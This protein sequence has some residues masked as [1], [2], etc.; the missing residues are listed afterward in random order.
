VKD[1]DARYQSIKEVAIELKEL[2]REMEHGAI[3]A[4]VTTPKTVASEQPDV[5]STRSE[6][7]AITSKE[8]SLSTRAS[9]AEYV[10]TGIKQHKI[11]LVIALIVL[12]ASLTAF[13]LYLRG[14]SDQVAITSIAVMPFVNESGNADVE[15][16]SDGMTETLIGSLSSVPNLSVKPRATVFRYKGKETDARTIGRDL[17]VQAILNG[18]VAQRGDQIMLSLELIDAE[19][20]IVL[21]SQQYDRKQSSIVLLQTEIAKDVSTK[22]K[23]RLTGAAK[24][25]LRRQSPPIPKRIRLI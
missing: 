17:N 1:R 3:D 19:K 25:R 18:R 15:Y 20:D 24:R 13:G 7:P 2:R 5:E 8:S 11:A 16:L 6:A 14:R 22:L 9:S 21:W 23:T 12:V 4:T 10:V